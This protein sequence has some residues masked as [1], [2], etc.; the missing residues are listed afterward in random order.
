ERIHSI[1][2]SAGGLQT[3]Q[4]SY[5][6]SSYIASVVTY[7]GGI[8][9]GVP[10]YENPENKFGAMI[11]HG[12]PSDIVVISFQDASE[13]YRENIQQNGN[14]AFICDHGDGH[15]IPQDGVPSSV[16]FLWDH[17]WGEVPSPYENGLPDSF[18]GYCEL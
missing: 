15:T 4:M 11:Y 1:G 16:D 8:F 13:M 17:P 18:P 14:F 5:R 10:P 6:R 7:S 3:S 9:A 2:M 12:G